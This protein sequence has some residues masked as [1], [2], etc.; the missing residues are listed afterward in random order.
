MRD[1]RARSAVDLH[2]V[3]RSLADLTAMDFESV[4]ST[5]MPSLIRI[6]VVC[7]WIVRFIL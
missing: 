3:R 2:S 1:L 7:V 5:S 4:C 6:T